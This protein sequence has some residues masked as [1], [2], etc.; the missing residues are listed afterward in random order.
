[1]VLLLFGHLVVVGR[2][3]RVRGGVGGLGGIGLGSR[4]AGSSRWQPCSFSGVVG[5]RAEAFGIVG[6][7]AKAF[8]VVGPRAKAFGVMK[9]RARAFGV[10]R[11][12]A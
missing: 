7:W 10:V 6:P 3:G 12:Q 5:P 9:P 11:P 1:M 4:D 8:G 2:S